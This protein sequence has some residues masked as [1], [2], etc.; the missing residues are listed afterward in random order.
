MLSQGSVEE[1]LSLPNR[2]SVARGGVKIN[3]GAELI[4][5]AIPYT[6]EDYQEHLAAIRALV[7]RE[8]NYHLTLLPHS[9]FQ[10]MQVITLKDAVAVLR[11]REPYTAFVFLNR[12][13]M[14]SV[15]DY[16]HSLLEQYAASRH[17]VNQ[18]L[19]ELC[20]SLD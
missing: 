5:Q 6:P 12:T 15:S 11:C 7:D 10:D 2:E 17:T 8:K 13:L 14:H 19:D 20:R 4:D 1:I 16:S 3:L 18:A 9:P